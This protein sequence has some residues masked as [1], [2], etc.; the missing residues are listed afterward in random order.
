M[1]IPSLIL[2]QIYTF[3][4]LENVADGVCF[5]LKNRLSDASVTGIGHLVA[6]MGL[7]PRK[8]R[9]EQ[10]VSQWTGS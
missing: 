9:E 10:I 8:I 2:E 5:G 7:E 3:G 1:K 4:S 6:G